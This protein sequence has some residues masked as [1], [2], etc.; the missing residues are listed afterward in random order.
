MD[1]VRSWNIDLIIFSPSIINLF[2]T[3]EMWFSG[4][5]MVQQIDITEKKPLQQDLK[6]VLD[7]I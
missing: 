2:H 5:E 3:V 7:D 6:R 1:I 4:Q